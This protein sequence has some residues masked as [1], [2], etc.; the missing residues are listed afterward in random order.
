MCAVSIATPGPIVEDT[1]TDLRYLP[2]A[3]DG[4]ALTTLSTSAWAF[5][6]RLCA[7][8]DVFPTGAW[9]IPVLS[10]RNSTL[11]ALISLIACA[12]FGRDGAGL[13]VRHQAARAEHLA[14]APD[15]AHHVGRRDDRVE[16]HPAAEDLLDDLVAADEVGAGFLRFLLLVGAGNRQHPL[17]LAEAVGQDD[18]AAHHLVRVLRID[19]RGAS[20]PRPSRRTW[21]TSPSESGESPP[22]SSTAGPRPAL[23]PP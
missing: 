22:R 18:R 12:T 7:G 2:F 5:S 20:P 23:R 8:N 10:T 15:A 17:A 4:F 11:P 14:E 9:M 16:V 21:R 6:I 1:V 3:A 19:A 13:R